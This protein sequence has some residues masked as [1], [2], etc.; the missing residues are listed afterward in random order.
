MQHINRTR[1]RVACALHQHYEYGSR[2]PT[3]P[4]PPTEHWQRLAT[5]WRQ[6]QLCERR[7]LPATQE[8][9][10]EHYLQT[11]EFLGSRCRALVAL[12][13]TSRR[14]P[15]PPLRS[16]YEE[17]LALE[18]EF[19]EVRYD[20]A[21]KT[22]S[23]ITE[24]VILEGI[25]LGPFEIRLDWTQ[26]P[27]TPPYEVLAL[28]PHPAGDSPGTTHPHVHDRIL[29]EGEAR[30][31]IRLALDQGRLGD[32][33]LL[34]NQVLHTYNPGSAYTKLADWEGVPCADC[35][36]PCPAE[37]L[38]PCVGCEQSSCPDC[39]SSCRECGD[40]LCSACEQRCTDCQEPH[41]AGCLESCAD[42]GQEVC[43]SCRTD[44]LCGPCHDLQQDP[45]DDETDLPYQTPA[46]PPPPSA[47]GETVPTPDPD[48]HPHRLGQTPLPA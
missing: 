5:L 38:T 35:G 41:C 26:L 15:P 32:V 7:S 16:L 18:Q 47:P 17:L 13:Q 19:P 2:E 43:P 34:I 20:L 37:D 42:C 9:L 12:S 22:V 25:E 11:L 8:R 48:L 21:E 23:I 33:G 29:C 4:D 14:S 30:E 6:L 27:L 28:E 36:G 31:A 10:Q 40:S 46:P 1:L 3:A 44:A 39:C 24:P 45:E